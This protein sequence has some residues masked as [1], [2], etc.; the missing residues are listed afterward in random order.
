MLPALFAGFFMIAW[1]TS[2]FL[3]TYAVLKIFLLKK[4]SY[5]YCK[6]Y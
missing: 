6:S 5:G 2:F 3:L 1:G 4:P